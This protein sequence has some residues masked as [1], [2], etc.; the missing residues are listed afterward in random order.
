MI[1]GAF[2]MFQLISMVNVIEPMP[3]LDYN[4]KHHSLLWTMYNNNVHV[5]LL[6]Q[7]YKIAFEPNASLYCIF[8]GQV[9]L[10]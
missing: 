2:V 8:I 10:K 6:L 7:I 9:F 1:L 5:M 4:S 3:S